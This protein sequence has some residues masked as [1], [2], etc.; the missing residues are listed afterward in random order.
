[1][2]NI[3]FIKMHGLGNDFVIV[4][5]RKH[6]C[7]F[8]S[9]EIKGIADRHRGVGCDQ[10][11]VIENPRL[12]QNMSSPEFAKQILGRTNEIP[13][14]FLIEIQG[15]TSDADCLVLFYN[16]DGSQSGACGNATR[17]VAW[18]IMQEK[19]IENVSLQTVGGFLKCQKK[20]HELVEVDMGQAKT[21]WQQ[22]PLAKEVDTLHLPINSGILKD[23]VAVSMGNPHAVFFVEDVEKVDLSACGAALENDDLFPQ[24]ANI[25]VAQIISDKIIKLRVW[26][27]GTGETEACG[28]GACAAAVASNLRGFTSGV[29]TV[30][31]AGG[32]LE[33]KY[34][35]GNVTMTGAVATSFT[36]VLA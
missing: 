18:L 17:C 13:L 21:N 16:A 25:G 1:M 24:R 32:D 15:M 3:P 20:G 5:S 28:T 6:N 9:D 22:I 35:D 7:T 29:V 2:K 23:G 33:I 4:D 10:F 34:K 19:N 12:P 8:T 11:V 26:E 31:L 36:G 27:R 30:K 14:E